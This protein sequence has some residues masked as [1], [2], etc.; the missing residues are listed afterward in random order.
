MIRLESLT[1]VFDTPK[2]AVVAADHIDM[3]VPEGDICV[4]LGPSGCGKTTTLKMINR[5]VKPTSGKVFINGDDTTGLD[6]QT[7]RRNIGYVIQQI[8]LFPNMTIEENI[9]IVPKL[10]GWDKAKYKARAREMM[11]M[12]ALEPDAFLKRFPS[13]LSGGQQ[14]RIGVAR[15]LAADPPVMLMDEP[16]G[17]IDPI[18]RAV[19]QDEFLKMQQEL[20]KTIMF[21]SHDI[22]EAIKMGDRVAVFREGQLV[23]YSTPDDL[24]AAPKNAFVES[25]LGE[26]RALKRLN[27]VKVREIVT[28]EI[29]TVTPGDTLETALA[30]IDNY[31]YQNAILMIN[32]RKQPAGIISRSIART[33]KGYCRDHFQAVPAVVGLDDDLRKAASLMFAH[34]QTWLPCVNEEG[35]VCGQITQRAMTSHLGARY[36]ARQGDD[37]TP[38]AAIKE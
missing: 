28:D 32:D 31:G 1:K 3:E 13:E 12:I 17:A 11:A 8:G 4:L 25:F 19:I 22:D 14:Q 2:G 18:N 10:L 9:T 37:R 6:T 24:L 15:A 23:Q 20:N 38:S 35:T 7:L 21:V 16:F 5:I 30:K 34:D 29:G 26:D 27:L 33:T 36:R